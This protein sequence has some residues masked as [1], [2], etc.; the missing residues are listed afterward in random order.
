MARRAFS[1]LEVVVA[2]SVM[3]VVMLFVA[4]ATASS[5]GSANYD[6]AA[7][8]LAGDLRRSIDLLTSELRDAGG[9]EFNN[10]YVGAPLT[11]AA[12]GNATAVTF[13]RRIALNSVDSTTTLNNWGPQITYQLTNGIGE[14]AGNGLDDDGDGLVDESRLTRTQGALTTDVCDNV[15]AFTLQRAATSDSIQISL[16][17]GRPYLNNGVRSFFAQVATTRVTLR[18]RPRTE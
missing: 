12:G 7:S 6:F 9:D 3:T 8:R 18:N 16:T 4:G 17:L 11:Y 14:I 2:G 13:R 10:D 5:V 1:L 15:V